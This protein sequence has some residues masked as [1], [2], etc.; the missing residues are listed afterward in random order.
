MKP[1]FD[2]SKKVP[3]ISQVRSGDMD[4]AYSS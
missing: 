4:T 3:I 2:V 1:V